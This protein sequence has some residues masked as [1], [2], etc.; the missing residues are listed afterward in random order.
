MAKELKRNKNYRKKM[1]TKISGPTE[2]ILPT[3]ETL[4][5]PCNPK[6][7][8]KQPTD[9]DKPDHAYCHRCG[10]LSGTHMSYSGLWPATKEEGL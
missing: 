9:E 7:V 10:D 2:E 4:C 8:S 3:D 5:Q 6:F 1:Q